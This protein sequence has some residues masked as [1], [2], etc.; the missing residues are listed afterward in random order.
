MATS[1]FTLFTATLAPREPTSSCDDT[2]AVTSSASSSPSSLFSVSIM[3]ATPIRSSKA[4]PMNTSCS[5]SYEKSV[6]GTMGSPTLILYDFSVSSFEED[7]I[8]IERSLIS[9]VLPLSPS[10]MKCT[11]FDAIIPWMYFPS[12]FLTSTLDEGSDAGF[13]PP[14]LWNLMVPFGLMECTMNPTS[15]PWASIIIMGLPEFPFLLM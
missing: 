12:A 15:S 8:S 1:G 3:A 9:R 4:F 11:G 10:F 7:P 2:T 5:S 13:Q 14:M 6:I